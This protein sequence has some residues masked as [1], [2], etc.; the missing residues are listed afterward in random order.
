MVKI[1]SGDINIPDI[2]RVP[3]AKLQGSKEE[4]PTR[5]SA[6]KASRGGAKDDTQK[7]TDLTENDVVRK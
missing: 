3:V 5:V 2:L 1:G 4:T 7:M 6:V